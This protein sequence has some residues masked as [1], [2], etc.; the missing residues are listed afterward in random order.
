MKSEQISKEDFLGLEEFKIAD[1]WKWYKAE[2]IKDDT[3]GAIVSGPFGSNI[4][5]KFFRPSGIPVIRGNNLTLGTSKFIDEGFVFI[6]E[7]KA[8]ELRNC[9]AIEDDVIF[10]AGGTIGQV[11][12]IPK[13]R[14]FDKYI[15]SNKQLRLR[16]DPKKVHPSYVYFWFSSKKMQQ[17]IIRLN[18]G[19]SVPLI[20]LSVLRS[21]PIPLPPSYEEQKRIV[22]ILEIL[23]DKIQF[24]EKQKIILKNIVSA[25]F[26][27]RFIDFEGQTEFEE[28]EIGEIPKGWKCFKIEEIQDSRRYATAMGP[29][30]SNIKAENYVFSGVPIIRG[31]NVFSGILNEEN[32][33]FLTEEKADELV[34]S[35][36]HPGDVIIV[37]QG[38]VGHVGI[39]P[40]Q[41]M[42]KRYVLSQNLM[43]LSCNEKVNSLYVYLYLKSKIGQHQLLSRVSITGVPAIA[44]PLSSLREVL[45]IIPPKELLSKFILTVEPFFNETVQLGNEIRYLRKIYDSILPKL[46]SGKIL[47]KSCL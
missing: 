11:G 39:I 20:T 21:L 17:H 40:K 45:I 29:F 42:Y 35:N 14:K 41:S 7:E 43:K 8:H 32:F 28:S 25:I 26:K 22:E 37:A 1:D 10:T 27:S 47:L 16:V 38:N 18:V 15:I 33:V 2:E 23:Y 36:S 46:M 6:D 5:A 24:L 9:E 3:K 19:S 13:E 12:I 31:K 34:S 30:G 4:S 44:K